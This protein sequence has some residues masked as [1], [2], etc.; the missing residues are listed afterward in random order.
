MT[1][2]ESTRE[3]PFCR[4]TVKAQA[5]RCRHCRAT[6]PPARPEHG[7]ICPY[8]KEDIKPEAI[9]CR[10]CQSDLVAAGQDCGCAEHPR[11]FRVRR[12][13][14][15]PQVRVPRSDG[16]PQVRVPRPR[17]LTQ[18][19]AAQ[20]REGLACSVCPDFYDFGPELGQ[21]NLVGCDDHYCY[22]ELDPLSYP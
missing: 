18:G 3:C 12:S 16:L 6:I 22:Y 1:D 11:T 19:R 4:E 20:S 2:Q 8:C 14:G 17:H 10:Y 5:T 7:G 15:R 21:Y 13:E 9:R